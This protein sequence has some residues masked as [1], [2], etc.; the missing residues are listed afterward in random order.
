MKSID[1]LVERFGVSRKTAQIDFLSE[2]RYNSKYAGMRPKTAYDA[3]YATVF[4]RYFLH[5][6]KNNDTKTK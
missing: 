5:Q 6:I 4:N 1:G 2:Y 3:A